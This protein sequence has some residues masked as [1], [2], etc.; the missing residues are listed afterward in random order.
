MAY[1]EYKGQMPPT[2]YLVESRHVAAARAREAV[3]LAS[4]TKTLSTHRPASAGSH[5]R[6]NAKKELARELEYSK[7]E[8]SNLLLLSKLHKTG[9]RPSSAAAPGPYRRDLSVGQRSMNV[10]LR[11]KEL[12]RIDRE[13]Q[14]RG[15]RGAGGGGEAPTACAALTPPPPPFPLPSAA[16]PAVDAHARAVFGGAAD[17]QCAASG[18]VDAAALGVCVGAARVRRGGGLCANPADVGAQGA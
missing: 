16:P 9:H 8:F 18:G 10:R 1:R 4:V 12:L 5:M 17:G 15:R 3:H 2:N 7:V 13:N 6:F 14:V 11:R